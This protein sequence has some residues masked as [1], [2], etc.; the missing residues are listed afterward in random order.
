MSKRITGYANWKLNRAGQMDDGSLGRLIEYMKAANPD[1]I[2]VTG[3]LINL[4]LDEEIRLARLWLDNLGPAEMVSAIP[5]NHDTYVAGALKRVIAAWQPFMTGDGG[6]REH[7]LHFPYLRVRDNVALIGGNS[8][9]ATLPFMA[10]GSFDKKQAAATAQILQK[11]RL[12]GL[13]RIVMIHHPPFPN[14]TPH[15]KRLIGAQRFR[16]MIAEHGAELVIH[17]H[18]HIESF[19]TIDGQNGPVPVV[20]VPSAS[21]APAPEQTRKDHD[22]RPPGRYNLFE[23]SGEPDAWSCSMQEHGYA[24]GS[25]SVVLIGDKEIWRKGNF[26]GA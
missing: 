20:G 11:T 7:N 12:D 26:A 16:A 6:N 25:R 4:G 13:F 14:A 18:T 19:E 9:L 8:G 1:H 17:G 15:H 24:N 21:K 3:D 10:T 5:G 22:H 2:A 23:I